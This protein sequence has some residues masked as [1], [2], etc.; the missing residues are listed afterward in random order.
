MF[1]A[2]FKRIVQVSTTR[3]AALF[4]VRCFLSAEIQATYMIRWFTSKY[5]C[6]E[7]QVRNLLSI[8][9]AVTDWMMLCRPTTQLFSIWKLI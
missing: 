7:V 6:T 9:S 8:S 2:S 1:V 3:S 4:P 5:Y